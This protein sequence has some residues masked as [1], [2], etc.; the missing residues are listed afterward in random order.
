MPDMLATNNNETP[1]HLPPEWSS[2]PYEL[3]S[4]M[5]QKEL[6]REAANATND[7]TEEAAMENILAESA[8]LEE[9]ARDI[10]DIEE[11]E[12]IRTRMSA[13][14]S[15]ASEMIAKQVSSEAKEKGSRWVAK[16]LGHGGN[17]IDTADLGMADLAIVWTTTFLYDLGRGVVSIF[18]PKPS[19]NAS[20]Q[21][22]VTKQTMHLLF[23][24]YKLTEPG[25]LLYFIV[26]CIVAGLV[27]TALLS[28][29][30]IIGYILHL[31]GATGFEALT[32][33][34]GS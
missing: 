32:A 27:M 15:Q 3:Q 16:I 22:D 23:P 28:I 25:D 8:A 20:F 11:L 10:E 5:R 9:Q 31:I 33:I 24:P 7:T 29:V 18:I 14:R 4:L 6:E 19:A 1:V 2:L 34:F 13:L 30:V 26:E 21:E 17:A 12:P